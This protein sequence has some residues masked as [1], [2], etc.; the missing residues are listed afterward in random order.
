[1][2]SIASFIGSQN[3]RPRT[4]QDWIEWMQQLDRN[5]TE[6]EGPSFTT[7]GL[8]TMTPVLRKTQ[9]GFEL[10]PRHIAVDICAAQ[11]PAVLM[12]AD[13]HWIDQSA[14]DAQWLLWRRAVSDVARARAQRDPLQPESHPRP[15]E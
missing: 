9:A 8:L 1:M 6:V 12:F 13:N 11:R 3:F 10:C 2:S 14:Q 15:H 4:D 5:C 7:P